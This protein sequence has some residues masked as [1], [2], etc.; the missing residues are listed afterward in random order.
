MRELTV[1]DKLDIKLF[2]EITSENLVEIDKY[3]T[4]EWE[5]HELWDYNF[6]RIDSSSFNC[7]CKFEGI[8]ASNRRKGHPKNVR[9]LD[10]Y[11]C[12]FTLIAGGGSWYVDAYYKCSCGQIWKE[13]F[14]EEM[15]Y[16]GNHAYPIDDEEFSRYAANSD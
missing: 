11:G 3:L 6:N 13:V 1:R 4:G 8:K 12:S 2:N 15:Q 7:L 14:V 9:D 10:A 5:W 16:T